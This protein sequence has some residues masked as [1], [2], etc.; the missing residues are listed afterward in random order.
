MKRTVFYIF[1]VFIVSVV[2]LSS[3]GEKKAKDGRTDTPISGTIKFAADESFSQFIDEELQ[4][5]QYR[6]PQTHLLPV[7]TDDNTG[8]KMLLDLK[9]NLLFSSHGLQKGEDAILRGKGPIP[10]VFP[11]GYDGIAFI[12]NKSN[13]DSCITVT[14]VKRLL[15]G[16]VTTWNQLYPHS[17]K[18]NIEVV[19]DNKASATLHFVVDSILEGKNIKSQ[20]IVAAKN[21]KSVIEYVKKTPNAIGVIGSNWL[22]D[23]SDSSN[24]T[25]RNDIRVMAI[26]KTS[27]A[28]DYNSWQPYQAYFLDGRYPF[29]RT[30]YA[31]VAD[32]HKALPWA[33]A[34]FIAGPIGQKIMLKTGL[35][36]YRGEITIREV[37]I[38]K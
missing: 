5:Y 14:D 32:P 16:E 29:V 21:S 15:K 35:L 22:N 27:K 31:I 3:C 6:F 17:D 24:T 26:S 10:S 33:F 7:Y 11:V 19:F 37:K 18:G 20:N 25:F 2:F 13:L 23:R 12:I 1:L 9:V 8:M 28:E 36:P 38:K 30:I 34:N 4:V